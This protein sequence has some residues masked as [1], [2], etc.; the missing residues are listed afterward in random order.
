MKEFQK[1]V[2]SNISKNNKLITIDEIDRNVE[3]FFEYRDRVFDT[4]KEFLEFFPI[5]LSIIYKNFGSF[6][7]FCE[8]YKIVINKRKKAKF[9]KQEIDNLVLN[10]IKEGNTIPKAAKE[11]VKLGLPSRDSIVRYYEDWHEPFVFY[12]KLYEK[13]N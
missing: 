9:T 2:G 6:D 12:S 3:K 1:L 8:K 13:I 4:R 10:Y 11:L 5:S 7:S